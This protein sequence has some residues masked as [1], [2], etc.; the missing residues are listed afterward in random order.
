MSTPGAGDRPAVVDAV[1]SGPHTGQIRTGVGF[2]HADSEEALAADDPRDELAPLRFGPALEQGRH[3]LAVGDP[4]R[5]HR[6]PGG[7]QLLGDRES[8]QVRAPV[9]AVLDWG[10]HAQ[11]A[12]PGECRGEVLVPAGQPGVDRGV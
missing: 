6:R 1:G 12:A 2:T 8:F 4:V 10:G 11:P 3:D 5:R 9:S 7:E